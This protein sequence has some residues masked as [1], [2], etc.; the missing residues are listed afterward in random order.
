L[1]RAARL[2][3]VFAG[4]FLA[5]V[6]IMYLAPSLLPKVTIYDRLREMGLSFSRLDFSTWSMQHATYLDQFDHLEWWKRAYDEKQAQKG[7]YD[8]LHVYLDTGKNVVWFELWLDNE[9]LNL[10][11]L[12]FYAYQE[13]D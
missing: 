12:G 5:G 6:L 1:K 11:Y 10:E 2:L 4:G 13:A 7:T 3:A 8:S 9:P